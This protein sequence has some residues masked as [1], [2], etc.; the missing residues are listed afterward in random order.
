MA[1]EVVPIRVLVVLEDAVAEAAAYLLDPVGT[2]WTVESASVLPLDR[3]HLTTAYRIAKEA[4]ANAARHAGAERVE[5]RISHRDGGVAVRVADDG[6]GMA[7]VPLRS[8]AGHLGMSSIRD[9]VEVA[10]GRLDIVSAPGEGTTV[11]FWLPDG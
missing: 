8:A 10:G 7:E 11:Q 3:S 4:L 5:V 2:T 9:W 6:V 1:G